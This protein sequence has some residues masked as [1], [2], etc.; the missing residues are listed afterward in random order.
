MSTIVKLISEIE[1]I[2][3][4]NEYLK[5][6]VEELEALEDQVFDNRPKLTEQEV[7]DIR[8]A[9]RGGMSQVALANNYGVN[10]STISRTVR[11]FYH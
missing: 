9:Y 1:A 2:L 10:P 5:K 3:E 6:R 8:A 11:G 7:K 4:E